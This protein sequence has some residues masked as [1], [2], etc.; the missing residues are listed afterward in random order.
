MGAVEK[1]IALQSMRAN[2]QLPDRIAE[3]PELQ[4]GLFLFLQAFFDLDNERHHGLGPMPIPFRAMVEYAT[5][6]EFDDDQFNALIHHMRY[7]DADHL[8]RIAAKQERAQKKHATNSTR[9]SKRTRR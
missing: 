1:T 5:F 8:K 4:D 7:M 2:E 9:P 6:H 3:A